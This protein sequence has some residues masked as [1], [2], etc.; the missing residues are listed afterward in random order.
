MD[1]YKPPN[2]FQSQTP[3]SPACQISL[4]SVETYSRIM[5]ANVQHRK[6][7]A[8]FIMLENYRYERV[9]SQ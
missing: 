3:V 2:N 5:Q 6:T 8:G 9:G 7:N 1:E 4:K